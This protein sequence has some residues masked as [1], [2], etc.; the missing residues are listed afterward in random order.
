VLAAVFISQSTPRWPHRIDSL[1][2]AGEW[3]YGEQ[4]KLYMTLKGS[5]YRRNRRLGNNNPVVNTF[6]QWADAQAWPAVILEQVGWPEP[7]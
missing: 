2:E 6:R 3:V 4:K 1:T 7:W 5:G